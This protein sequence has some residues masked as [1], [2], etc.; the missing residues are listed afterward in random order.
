MSQKELKEISL[1]TI[2][3]GTPTSVFDRILDDTELVETLIVE[4]VFG[5]IMALQHMLPNLSEE[6]DVIGEEEDWMCTISLATYNLLQ[7]TITQSIEDM[8]SKRTVDHTNPLLFHPK[9]KG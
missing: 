1:L 3:K 5:D 8:K 4:E 9:E 2:F 6:I 7:D